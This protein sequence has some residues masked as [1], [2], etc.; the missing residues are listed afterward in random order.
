[1]TLWQMELVPWYVFAA[2]WVFSSLRLKRIKVQENPWERAAHVAVMVLAFLLL[3]SRSLRIGPLG[4]RFVPESATVQE[5]GILLTSLGV[6]VAVWAR[7]CLGQ[8]WSSRV[9]LKVDHQ[10]IRSGPYAYIRHPIYAGMLLA[11]VGTALA[12]G[13]WRAFAGFG[14]ALIGWSRKAMT[15]EALLASEFGEQYRAYQ[16]QTG[17][18]TP[19]FW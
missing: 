5:L 12:V 7:Y 4:L 18:L 2:Y 1:M 19:R 14:L 16:R 10:L 17:F 9:V 11:V 6:A 13:E 3:F 8:Y 15:E